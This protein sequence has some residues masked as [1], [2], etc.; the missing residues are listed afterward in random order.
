M[1]IAYYEPSAKEERATMPLDLVR[2]YDECQQAKGA[3]LL[4][5][6]ADARTPE[7]READRLYVQAHLDAYI[8]DR[9]QK[10]GAKAEDISGV[11]HTI[12][13]DPHAVYDKA[14]EELDKM[15]WDLK[16]AGFKT[17]TVWVLGLALAGSLGYIYLREAAAKKGKES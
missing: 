12:D 5:Q 9:I 13:A 3:G 14:K 2:D 8:R 1:G 16:W 11:V 15:E 6:W 4:K 7:Q 10:G 17:T